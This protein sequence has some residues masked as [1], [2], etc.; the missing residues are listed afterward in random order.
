M[1]LG[2]EK[3]RLCMTDVFSNACKGVVMR[4]IWA[5]DGNK[6]TEHNL[7]FRGMFKS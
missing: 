2:N 7:Y 4:A 5:I 3:H 6:K 1:K